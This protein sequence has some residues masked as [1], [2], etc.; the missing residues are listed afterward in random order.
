MLKKTNSKM[1]TSKMVVRIQAKICILDPCS[2]GALLLFYNTRMTMYVCI[3]L[4]LS[5]HYVHYTTQYVLAC[6]RIIPVLRIC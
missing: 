1:L 6:S 2:T 3:T 5:D 4:S